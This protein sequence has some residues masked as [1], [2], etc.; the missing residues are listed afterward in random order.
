MLLDN[1][2]KWKKAVESS[3]Y[4]NTLEYVS[5]FV[6]LG[7]NETQ[8]FMNSNQYIRNTAIM[9]RVLL[10]HSGAILGSGITE[11]QLSDYC[12]VNQI[13]TL[14][15]LSYTF[16][17]VMDEDDRYTKNLVITGANLTNNDIEVKEWG[18]TK[19]IQTRDTST[20]TPATILLVREVLTTPIVLEAN[21][22]FSITVKWTES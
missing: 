14:S 22:G 20:W 3:V 2:W 9:N 18:F 11:P 1:Y 19:E 12:L 17:T 21:K 8:M 5:G 6:D 15:N 4:V 16:N 7:G 13:Q 10:D